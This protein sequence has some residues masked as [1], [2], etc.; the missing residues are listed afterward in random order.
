VAGFEVSTE[1]RLAAGAFEIH[2]ISWD[3]PRA[4]LHDFVRR[5]WLTK[6]EADALGVLFR[7]Y[8]PLKDALPS[9]IKRALW[10]HEYAS[11]TRDFN[12][13]LVIVA[14]ALEALV[15]TDRRN[16]T[17]QFLRT[18]QIAHDLDLAFS[19]ADGE[20]AYDIRSEVAHGNRLASIIKQDP[21]TSEGDSVA[22]MTG[23]HTARRMEGL[24]LSM[25]E[26]LRTAI[27][28]A[29]EQ[30]PFRELFADDDRIRAKWP[31]RTPKRYK[32]SEQ[33]SGS[34]TNGI[35]RQDGD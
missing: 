33:A 13:R 28:R 25:E 3:N 14:S 26:I 11:R 9:R 35:D 5:R 17:G 12:I 1:V 22:S 23:K 24:L 18:V 16:S 15:H 6:L 4:Y 19:E 20:D 8:W 31:I 21:Q 10:N 30:A 2:P 32:K 34:L 27:R 29:I 7:T